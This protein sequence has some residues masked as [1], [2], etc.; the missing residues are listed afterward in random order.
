MKLK[1]ILIFF[2]CLQL[3]SCATTKTRAEKAAEKDPRYQYK[4][5]LFYL[6]SNQLDL[7]IKHL[8]N[9]LTLEPKNHLALNALGFA[10]LKKGNFDESIKYFSECLKINPTLTEA[11][12]NLGVSYQEMGLL[13]KAEEHFMAASMDTQYSSREHPFFNLA[14]LYFIQDKMQNAIFQ[15]QKS[16]EIKPDFPRALNLEGKIFS[17]MGQFDNAIGS[18]EKAIKISPDDIDLNFNLAE[19]YFNNGQFEK[20]KQIF[21]AISLKS[22]DMEMKKKIEDYLRKIK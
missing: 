9:S 3:V 15:V 8:K 21:S 1:T 11:Q 16:L 10:Y 5:G 7:S 13:D 6:N 2:V 17:K 22:S 18:F 19:A 20:A 12:N 4:M 14:R